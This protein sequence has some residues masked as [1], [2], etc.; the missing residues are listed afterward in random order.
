MASSRKDDNS[1]SHFNG[2]SGS[3]SNNV[4]DHAVKDLIIYIASVPGQMTPL[5]TAFTLTQVNEKFWNVNKPMEMFY[6]FKSS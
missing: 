4:K 3:N 6:S 5:N 2:S 1:G